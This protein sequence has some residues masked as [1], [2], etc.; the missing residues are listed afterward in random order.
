MLANKQ[1]IWQPYSKCM[2]LKQCAYTHSKRRSKKHVLRCFVELQHYCK[3]P[4]TNN[5]STINCG[6]ISQSQETQLTLT[7]KLTEHIASKARFQ[8]K[9]LPSATAVGQCSGA[10]KKT[11][12]VWGLI[13]FATC[14]LEPLWTSHLTR[15]LK[16]WGL[17]KTAHFRTRKGIFS[18][19]KTAGLLYRSFYLLLGIQQCMCRGVVGGGKEEEE[20]YSCTLVNSTVVSE[21]KWV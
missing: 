5:N 16:S 20:D 6:K 8:S 1:R 21:L 13:Q 19:I 11:F 10:G 3:N 4:S 2:D 9:H 12:P 14:T 7:T 17:G 15:T 18:Y